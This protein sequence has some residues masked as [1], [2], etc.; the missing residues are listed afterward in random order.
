MISS[1]NH[2]EII[3]NEPIS[4]IFDISQKYDLRCHL[5]QCSIVR[6]CPWITGIPAG[7]AFAS[8]EECFFSATL[9]AEWEVSFLKL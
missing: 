1:Y 7:A 2:I 6:R 4:F 3:V 9:F 8:D 5:W